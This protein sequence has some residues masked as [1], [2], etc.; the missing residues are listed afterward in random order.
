MNSID[1][2]TNLR[3]PPNSIEAEHG[4]LGSILLD[5]RAY[6]R[7]ADILKREHFYRAEH[8]TIFAAMTALVMADKPADV[9]TVFEALGSKADDVGGMVF[10]N[11]LAQNVPSAINASAYAKLIAEKALRRTLITACNDAA[12][13]AYSEADSATVLDKVAALFAG[14]ERRGMSHQPKILADLVPARLDRITDM[15]DGKVEPGMATGIARLDTLL[16]GGLRG[17]GVYVL[18][19]RPGAGKSSLAQFIG[20]H[21]AQRHGPVL[22]LSLEMPDTEVTDRALCSLGRIDY[23]AIQ[24]G[25]LEGDQWE[26]LTEACDRAQQLR[27]YVD[28]QTELRLADIRAKARQVRGLSLLIVDYLQ[29]CAG[30]GDNRNAEVEAIS[31]GLKSLAKEMGVPILLLSQLNREVERRPGKEPM[32]SDLRDSGAIEQDADV[33]VFLWPYEDGLVACKLDKNRQGKKGRFLL[34]FDGGLQRWGESTAQFSPTFRR[35]RN[36]DL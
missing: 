33:V 32:L 26:R 19:A 25:K 21:H 13:L 16:S 27:F 23:A 10:L 34:D 22:M 6:D 24:T 36:D 9:V 12:A 28:S 17:G 30:S 29:L 35:G 11:Q 8:R 7:V 31:R 15:A 4:L 2:I 3:V 14:L 5:N 20:L 18:A 1:D